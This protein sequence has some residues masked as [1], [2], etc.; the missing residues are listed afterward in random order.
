[1]TFGGERKDILKICHAAAAL[2]QPPQVFGIL[3][4]KYIQPIATRSRRY[5]NNEQE[6]KIVKSEIERLQSERII[7]ES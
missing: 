2:V 5:E 1:M 4:P 7:I 6:N 3:S